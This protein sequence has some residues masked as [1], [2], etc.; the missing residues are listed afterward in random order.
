MST[1]AASVWHLLV[2]ALP[3]LV[4]SC[5]FDS[6]F[7]RY[8]ANNPRCSDAALGAEAGAETAMQSGPE[9]G[10]EVGPEAG[11]DFAPDVAHDP[12]WGPDR[13]GGLPPPRFGQI[14]ACASDNDC[15][16]NDVCHPVGKV[17]MNACRSTSDCMPTGLDVCADLMLPGGNQRKVCMCGSTTACQERLGANFRCNS[18][19]QLCEPACTAPEPDYCGTLFQPPRICDGNLQVCQRCAS[20]A[21]CPSSAQ[22]HCDRDRGCMGCFDDSDCA[23]RA[24]SQCNRATGACEA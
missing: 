15:G 20:N 16:R 24:E 14:V 5:D 18:P 10:P 11:P 2:V 6:A 22:P 8:C 23:G 7:D 3:W 9:V 1:R 12:P 4:S 17:C 13:D 21:D 19:E